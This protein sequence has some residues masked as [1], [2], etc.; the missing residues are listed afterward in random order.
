MTKKDYEHKT[1]KSMVGG[2][3]LAF[4][5]ITERERKIEKL[6]RIK[7]WGAL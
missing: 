5:L 3:N 7:N 4:C 1:S 6:G 2:W